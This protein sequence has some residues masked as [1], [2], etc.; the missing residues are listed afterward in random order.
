MNEAKA[1]VRL[2]NRGSVPALR[3]AKRKNEKPSA[4]DLFSVDVGYPGLIGIEC[5]GVRG[6]DTRLVY[7]AYPFCHSASVVL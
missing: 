5:H 3:F 1:E 6:R 7:A 2:A 4:N